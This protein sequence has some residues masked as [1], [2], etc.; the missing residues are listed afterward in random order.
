MSS[1]ALVRCRA[2]EIG[3]AGRSLL[4]PI[5]LEIGAGELWVVL[6]RNGAGKT[7][8][9][10][11]MLG[12]NPPVSGHVETVGKHSLRLAYAPQRSSFDAL[13][14]LTARDVV[15]LGVERG[16]SFLRPTRKSSLVE[17][18]L[19]LTG[20][21]A[22]AERPFRSLSE[23]ERQRVLLAR[24]AASDAEL[25]MLDEPTSALDLVAE[26]EA[27]TLMRRL[28]QETGM[29]LCVVTHSVRLAKLADR[30]L[31]FDRDTPAI[32]SGTPSEVL[33]HASFETSFGAKSMRPGPPEP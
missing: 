33:A 12:L 23:G 17:R 3:Y 20:A 11:T 22:L 21:R 24:I 19:D 8:W 14:P 2:L 13:Y 6:G 5:D 28:A 25:A 18:A 4:P 1:G 15:A 30:A 10:K 16:A 7:V 27:L 9:L 31:L 26:R 32:V 29:S